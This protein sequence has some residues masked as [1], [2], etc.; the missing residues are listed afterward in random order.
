MRCVDK[1]TMTE[2]VYA[3]YTY[4]DNGRSGKTRFSGHRSNAERF[5]APT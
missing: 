2:S 5:G 4:A 3:T 1:S